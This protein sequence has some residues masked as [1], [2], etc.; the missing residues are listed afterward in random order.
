MLAACCAPW[1]SGIAAS[2][3]VIKT[4]GSAFENFIQD[5]Y[6]TLKAV[7]DRI[8]STSVDVQYTFAPVAL[9]LANL[10]DAQAYDRVADGARAATLEV[11]ATD[12]SASVQVS[13]AD[14]ANPAPDSHLSNALPALACRRLCTRCARRYWVSTLRWTT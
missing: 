8:F 5:E 13:C 10:G 11:F 3:I 14:Q 1:P 9:D 2:E 7:N 6:T 4:T 12:E